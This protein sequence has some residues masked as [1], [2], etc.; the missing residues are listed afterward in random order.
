M[1]ERKFTEADW[2]LF[3]KKIPEWQENYMERLIWEYIQLLSDN[4]APSEKFWELD[5]RINE[6]KNSV[7]VR[8]EMTRSSFIK[9]IVQLIHEGVIHLTD[10]DEFSDTFKDTV[11]FVCERMG[12]IE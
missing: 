2:K 7:G 8:L 6:D 10:L 11:R 1:Q 4:R 12:N 5:R 9:N 3:K